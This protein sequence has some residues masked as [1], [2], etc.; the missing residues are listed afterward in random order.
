MECCNTVT[1]IDQS[2]YPAKRV[3]SHHGLPYARG[4]SSPITFI[5]VTRPFSVAMEMF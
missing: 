4:R 1:N 2:I 5:T 3:Y